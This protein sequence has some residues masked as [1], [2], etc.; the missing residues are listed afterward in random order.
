MAESMVN[1]VCEVAEGSGVAMPDEEAEVEVDADVEANADAR[2][3]A[4]AS[5]DAY[6]ERGVEIGG[7]VEETPQARERS[8]GGEGRII[9][10]YAVAED[11]DIEE[12][13]SASP[14]PELPFAAEELEDPVAVAAAAFAFLT[15]LLSVA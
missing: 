4:V 8:E 14:S 6:E 2:S 10:L 9:G 11:R 1:G 3:E 13:A 12:S 5:D 15:L 7:G